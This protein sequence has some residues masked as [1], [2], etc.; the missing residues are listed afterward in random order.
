MFDRRRC[1]RRYYACGI[2][3][4]F[5]LSA[6]ST[7]YATGVHDPLL[8]SALFL[9]DGKTPLL[10]VANDVLAVSRDA[11]G[12]ARGHIGSRDGHPAANMMITATHTHSGPI[13]F[14]CPGGEADQDRSEDRS[15]IY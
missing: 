3:I 9:S 7:R 12:R 13:T 14:D 8:S 10:L 5:R 15:A 6:R 4:P 2:A 1:D 11:A